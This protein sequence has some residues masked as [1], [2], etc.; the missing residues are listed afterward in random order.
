MNVMRS[1]FLI[2]L[3]GH[4][5]ASGA[6]AEGA[7]L[8]ALLLSGLAA[9][10]AQ[11]E[12]GPGR[13]HERIEAAVAAAAP[14]DTIL[15]HPRA[16]GTPYER[17]ALMVRTPGLTI[18]A[19]RTSGDHVPLDGRGFDYSGRGPTPR[20]IVQFDRSAHGGTL[21]GFALSGA[22]N[23][24]HNGAGV[25]I[26]QANNVT[27]RDCVIR[28]N[29]MGIM[30]SGDG[31]VTCA[32]NQRIERCLIHSN[33]DRTDPGY[34]HNL[35]LGGGDVT[36]WRTE[37]HSSLT[38]HNV[39]SRAHRIEIR[40]CSLHDSANREVDLVDADETGVAGSDALLVGN[41]IFKATNCPGNRAVIHCGQDGGK[42]RNGMLVMVS[43]TVVTLYQAPVIQV[44]A[45]GVSLELRGNHF[46]GGVAK[47]QQRL[48]DFGK[49]PVLAT[50]AGNSISAAFSGPALDALSL[51]ETTVIEAATRPPDWGM[52]R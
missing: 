32:T 45:S 35:Y 28:A 5:G 6:I 1:S 19:V 43:N 46:F 50:G 41:H 8:L 23:E 11:I 20:A 3:G 40:E 30:S 42:P 16:G 12:V 14:G 36:L 17:V 38:G 25:R 22:H 9:A 21:E 49:H 51:A 39:K 27:I 31:L 33:G 15:V 13:A 2:R 7:I 24:S 34:N 4:V 37:V 29:D 18:R 47:G 44:S 10:A 26:N 52:E 48:V